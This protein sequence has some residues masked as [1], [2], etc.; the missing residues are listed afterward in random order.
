MMMESYRKALDDRDPNEPRW[1]IYNSLFELSR[2][3]LLESDGVIDI[4]LRTVIAGNLVPC[5]GYPI[6]PPTPTALMNVLPT[7][8]L[9]KSMIDI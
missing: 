1:L 7:D 5:P 4:I 8:D 9:V 6:C 3:N 2:D